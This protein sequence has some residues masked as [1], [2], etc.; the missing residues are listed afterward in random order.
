MVESAVWTAASGAGDAEGTSG[1]DE[2]ASEPRDPLAGRNLRNLFTG[3]TF[4]AI[5][6]TAVVYT[7]WN[8]AAGTYGFF[9]PY[10]LSTMG[11]ESQ[12][13]D[14][15]L[16]SLWFLTTLV[17]VVLIFMPFGDGRH[18]RLIFAVGAGCQIVA[19]L[20]LVFFP[21]DGPAGFNILAAIANIILFGIGA[22]LAGEPFYKVWSQELFPTML[23]TT[24]QGLT[25]AVARTALGIWSF[26]VPVIA[27]AGFEVVALILVIF[28]SI[29]GI[30]GLLFMPNTAG[31]S[32]EEIEAERTDGRARIPEAAS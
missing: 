9:L 3:Y 15:A 19:F 18:R 8:L 25:F 20:L 29:S 13:A 6:F 23:R 17:L 16:Q 2:Q 32:L 4:R 10:F 30:V 24:A 7:F 26:F 14:V 31:K 22:A 21:L 1:P 5:V 28:L 12:A 11:L 27:E